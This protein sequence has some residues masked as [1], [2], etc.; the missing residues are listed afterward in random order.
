M[1]E[2]SKSSMIVGLGMHLP[3]MNTE[4]TKTR[5][6]IREVSKCI[7]A[8]ERRGGRRLELLSGCS[9]IQV[10]IKSRYTCGFKLSTKLMQS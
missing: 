1:G 5:E 8:R 2:S 3:T 10:L 4:Y 7:C 6:I 9:T